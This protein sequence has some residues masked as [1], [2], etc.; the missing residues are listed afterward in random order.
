MIIPGRSYR[1]ELPALTEIEHA[2]YDRMKHDVMILAEAIGERNTCRPAKL[3]MAEEF[4]LDRFS[5][6]GYST[7]LETFSTDSINVSN[8]EATL[9]GQSVLLLL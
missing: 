8:I 3:A 7:R 1:G 4:I 2:C 5:L 9:T 6:L